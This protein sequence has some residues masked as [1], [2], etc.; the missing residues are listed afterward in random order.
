MTWFNSISQLYFLSVGFGF[1]WACF[2]SYQ[3]SHHHKTPGKGL[4]KISQHQYHRRLGPSDCGEAA[5]LCLVGCSAV[6]RAFTYHFA[7]ILDA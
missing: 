6:S 2:V 7:S 3:H 4:Q 1:G 5:V